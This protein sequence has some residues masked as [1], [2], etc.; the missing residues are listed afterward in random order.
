MGF[1][2]RNGCIVP[3]FSASRSVPDTM[4]TNNPGVLKP[5]GIIVDLHAD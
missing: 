1:M 4:I 5:L 3:G 2:K